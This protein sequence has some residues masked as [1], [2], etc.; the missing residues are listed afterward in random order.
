MLQIH[1]L[2]FIIRFRFCEISSYHMVEVI[3]KDPLV[4]KPFHWESQ[5]VAVDRN[6]RSHSPGLRLILGRII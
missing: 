1:L 2:S 6:I 4:N 3:S 5:G